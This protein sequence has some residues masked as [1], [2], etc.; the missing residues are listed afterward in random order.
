MMLFGLFPSTTKPNQTNSTNQNNPQKIRDDKKYLERRENHLA[1][2]VPRY[3]T[4]PQHLQTVSWQ[5][6]VVCAL[7][8]SDIVLVF[9]R[10]FHVWPRG[11]LLGVHFW[12]CIQWAGICLLGSV[13]G[14]GPSVHQFLGG[15]R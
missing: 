4:Q 1:I 13:C 11:S 15:R 12:F 10:P 7:S 8:W 3:H 9:P 5:M 14:E 6:C 2:P